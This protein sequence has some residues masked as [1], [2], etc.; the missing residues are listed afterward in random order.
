MLSQEV[1]AQ[2]GRWACPRCFMTIN[3]FQ[4]TSGV[5]DIQWELL[6]NLELGN[7]M[8]LPGGS[9][10]VLLISRRGILRLLRMADVEI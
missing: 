8:N 7:W 2:S 5:Q 10:P 4:A 1:S 3:Q 9:A 6:D